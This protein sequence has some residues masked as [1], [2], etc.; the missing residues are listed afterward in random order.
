MKIKLEEYPFKSISKKLN[1]K[2]GETS[3]EYIYNLKRYVKVDMPECPVPVFA[4]KDA[5]SLL[6][7]SKIDICKV[8]IFG[9]LSIV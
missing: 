7:Y 2:T 3:E 6:D 4:E 1:E 9:Y 8:G 5:L